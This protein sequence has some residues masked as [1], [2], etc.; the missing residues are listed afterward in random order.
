MREEGEL[1]EWDLEEEAMDEE[2]EIIDASRG[3]LGFVYDNL[4][5]LGRDISERYLN[6]INEVWYMEKG[7]KSIPELRE[8][9]ENKLIYLLHDVDSAIR[10]LIDL[11]ERRYSD[12]RCMLF[13]RLG[14]LGEEE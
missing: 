7:T 5:I 8:I 1:E 9:Y 3:E 14:E 12:V 2:M 13:K 4:E 10:E 6:L 11:N